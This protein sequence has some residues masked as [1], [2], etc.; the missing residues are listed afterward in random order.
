MSAEEK[1]KH[2]EGLESFIKQHKLHSSIQE[3]LEM[4]PLLFEESNISRLELLIAVGIDI[5]YC[6]IPEEIYTRSRD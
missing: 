3:I 1:I 6:S 4:S 5:L 2:L